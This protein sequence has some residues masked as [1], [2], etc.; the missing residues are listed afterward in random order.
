MAAIKSANK[1]RGFA[2]MPVEVR[3]AIASKG[4]KSVP[5]DKRSFSARRDLP[6]RAGRTGGLA[7]GRGRRGAAG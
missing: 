6:A 1:K 3:R 2:C 7:N 4:G 5:A